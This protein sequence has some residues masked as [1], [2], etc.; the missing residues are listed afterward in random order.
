MSQVFCTRGKE[1]LM[2]LKKS[3]WLP[4]FDEEAVRTTL[5]EVVDLIDKLDPLY[6]ANREL[7]KE[8]GVLPVP[9]AVELT[10]YAAC[11][12]R[13][14]RY[15]LSYFL[16]RLK[17][18][19]ELRWETG[20]VIPESIRNETLNEREI[21]YFN[22]YNDTL[23]NYNNEIGF[24]FMSEALEPPRDLYVEV[25]VLKEC[26]EIVTERGPVTLDQ[27]STHYLK[28]TDI[29]HLIRLGHLEMFRS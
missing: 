12:R 5:Q 14:L 17:K 2:D 7:R 9:Q 4:T 29:E 3:E 15:L 26:G 13:N 20:T 1:M 24:D 19:R 18:L 21:E 27:G 22:Q 28:R 8:G 23:A 16:Y 6:R 10:Y 11:L 25:R